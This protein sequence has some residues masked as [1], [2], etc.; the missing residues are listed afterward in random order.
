MSRV[1]RR[2]HRLPRDRGARRGRARRASTARLR[3]ISPELVEAD[4]EARRLAE[5]RLARGVSIFIAIL[6]LAF[7]IL[8]HEAG[9]FF[10]SL[11]VGLAP[12]AR[13]T[14]ASRPRS[15]RRRATASSTAIGAIPLGGFVTIPGMHR[16]IPHDAERRFS[17]AVEEAPDARRPGRPREALARAATTSTGRSR[18]STSSRRRSGRRQLSPAARASAEKGLT[19]LRDALGPDAYWK[20][21][22]WKRLVAIARR[23][24]REHRA[25]DRRSSRS[26]S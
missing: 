10:A 26:C 19:E 5:R 18:R 11:A 13:S 4:A 3:A 1:P 8:V 21:P 17:R 9:H 12:A 23:A 14:S 7:L 24:G 22:T 15:R 20:A 25:D 16:P 6:G 2:T